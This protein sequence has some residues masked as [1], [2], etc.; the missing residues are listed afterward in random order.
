MGYGGKGRARPRVPAA[1]RNP[2]GDL[3]WDGH[4]HGAGESPPYRGVKLRL[5][6]GIS[7][8]L[9]V[10]PLLGCGREEE[11]ADS[12]SP[13]RVGVLPGQAEAQ[14]RRAYEPLLEHLAESTGL[15]FELTIAESYEAQVSAFAAGEVDLAWFGGLTFVQA[16]E[17]AGAQPLVMR[18]VD[19]GF[20]SVFVVAGGSTVSSLDDLRGGSFAF[21]PAQSTSGHLMPRAFLLDEGFVPAE[22]FASVEHT[23]G[24]DQTARRVR[25]GA[26]SAGAMNPRILE[27]MTR[28]GRLRAG[29]LRVVAET[30]PYHN[31]VW[32]TR[33]DM[34]GLVRGRIEDAFLAL[35][36]TVPPDAAVLDGLGASYFLPAGPKDYGRL[37]SIA[38]SLGLLDEAG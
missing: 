11:Q 9:L 4:G 8:W 2:A 32:A 18:D 10:M 13:V 15:E 21:G 37:R 16:W 7:I 29:D 23:S 34:D 28:D 36:P 30:A 27:A 38:Q 3:K 19:L 1:D 24:H 14:L 5:V 31:Y 26:V 20:T 35:D 17:R 33:S 22:F 25:D 6:L 12:R